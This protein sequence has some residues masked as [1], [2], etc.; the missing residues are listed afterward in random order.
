MRAP[1]SAR[2]DM[3]RTVGLAEKLWAGFWYTRARCLQNETT[4]FDHLLRNKVRSG[5]V[6]S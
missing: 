2:G 3:S 1:G 6:G 4:L 5:S